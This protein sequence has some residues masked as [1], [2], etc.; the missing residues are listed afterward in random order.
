MP[1]KEISIFEGDNTD[2]EKLLEEPTR[3][4]V[5]NRIELTES[6]DNFVLTGTVIDETTTGLF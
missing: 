3:K 5:Q 2:I 4:L 6:G 1:N